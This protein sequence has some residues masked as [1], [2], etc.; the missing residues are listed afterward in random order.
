MTKNF[1]CA[2]GCRR[3]DLSCG[4]II[5]QHF[6]DPQTIHI[7]HFEAITVK[8]EMLA[9]YRQMTELT[10]HLLRDANLCCGIGIIRKYA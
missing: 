6:I 2:H 1:R 9:G 8:L 5:D 4:Q 3:G 7:H 10:Q